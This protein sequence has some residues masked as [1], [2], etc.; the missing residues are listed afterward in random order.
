[1]SFYWS[2]GQPAQKDSPISVGQFR[3]RKS[4][5]LSTAGVSF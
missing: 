4:L 1:M 5:T 3:V 2:I